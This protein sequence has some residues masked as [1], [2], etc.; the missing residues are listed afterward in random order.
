[1]E[2]WRLSAKNSSGTCVATLPGQRND[3]V[4]SVAFDP[5]GT[6]M[7]T[8][9]DDST[10][11]LWR[12]SPDNSSATCVETLTGHTGRVV[13]VAFDST[14]TL[15]ATGSWDYTAK[16]WRL[17]ANKTSAT[18]VNTL[19]ASKGGHAYC[20]VFCVAFHPTAPLLATGSSYGTAKFWRLSPDGSQATCVD[21]LT[22][23]T[24]RVVSVAFDPTGTFLATGSED[25]TAKLWR[26]SS[27]NSS[28][29]CVDTLVHEDREVVWNKTVRCV[30]F[31]PTAPILA[32]GSGSDDGD[33][34]A[35]L[36]RLSYNSSADCV[37][38]LNNEATVTC[39]A[40]DPTGA[41]MATGRWDMTPRGQIKLWDCRQFT[42][43]NVTDDFRAM[44]RVI[45]KRLVGDSVNGHMSMQNAIA[46]RVAYGSNS[47]G[48][49]VNP[50]TANM[51]RGHLL[52][53]YRRSAAANGS[54]VVPFNLQGVQHKMNLKLL[55]NKPA[56]QSSDGAADGGSRARR[57]KP[58]SKSK[59]K[60]K[61]MKR[62]CTTL[63]R[64]SHK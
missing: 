48:L 60:S 7:A 54:V 4:A 11:K 3:A 16:L 39:L 58:K 31:H 35:K 32:T 17:S 63:K 20:V 41:V 57:S 52:D 13:S 45:A 46:A 23:H 26:L 64:K 2:L 30:A 42:R 10:V 51:V 18:C 5:T 1:V 47:N 62:K 38:T 25:G 6:L 55:K 56:D 50:H 36:W 15:L 21:T 27:D 44:Q 49:G 19:D 9:H 22:G 29:T 53:S 34:T 8:G 40:F 12:L 59:S 43:K 14:G 61:R 37:A 28:A 24:G 33:G